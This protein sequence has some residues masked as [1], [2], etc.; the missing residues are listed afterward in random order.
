M[1]NVRVAK[2]GTGI[3]KDIPEVLIKYAESFCFSLLCIF[4]YA[5]SCL[6]H[7]ATLAFCNKEMKIMSSNET[8]YFVYIQEKQATGGRRHQA[9]FSAGGVFPKERSS[10]YQSQQSS[11]AIQDIISGRD[12]SCNMVV[13]GACRVTACAYEFPYVA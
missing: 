1:L 10:R 3:F 6:L 7:I 9:E 13:A 2:G 5:H 4:V 11:P 12:L 8:V